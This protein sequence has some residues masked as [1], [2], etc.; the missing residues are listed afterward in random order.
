MDAIRNVTNTINTF[1]NLFQSINCLFWQLR[2]LE[3]NLNNES[4]PT[5]LLVLAIL[6]FAGFYTY[7][8]STELDGGICSDF[9]ITVGV[10]LVLVL[11][12]VWLMRKRLF[13]SRS[14]PTAEAVSFESER[15]KML[16]SSSNPLRDIEMVRPMHVV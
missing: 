11:V 10:V 13:V 6:G 7:C 2:W 14:I 8:S 5:L 9:I 12:G 4:G 1:V 3:G 15:E 16:G